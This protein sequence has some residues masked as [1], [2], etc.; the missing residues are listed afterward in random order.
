MEDWIS[1][2]AFARKKG[3]SHTAV[4][5]AVR[6]GRIPAAAVKRAADGRIEGIEFHSAAAAWDAHTD[7]AAAAKN[8]LGQAPRDGELGLEA[9][10]SAPA[11]NDE[12]APGKDPHGY[13]AERAKRE[14][15]AAATAELE[16][17]KAIGRVVEVDAMNEAQRR[18]F[19]MLRDK[20]LNIADR[21]TPVV[22]AERDP[23]RVHAAIIKEIEQV[24]NE[25]SD[26]ARA[27]A[28]GGI[29]ERL[30]A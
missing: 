22:T 3:V 4:Q 11:G 30:A 5:K 26:D 12:P 23:A 18:L 21:I 25:L 27:E 6:D 14:K 2:R 16:Y 7:P 28:T 24:L 10:A 15:F 29:A 13:Q 17:N 19:R 1:Q 8:T 9:K 20:F